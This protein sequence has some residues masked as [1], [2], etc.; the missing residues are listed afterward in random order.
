VVDLVAGL[1]L[2][3]VAALLAAGAHR[4]LSALRRR[5]GL[6]Y[7]RFRER[8]LRAV[9]WLVAAVLVLAVAITV[10]PL[11]V[12]RWA[13]PPTTAFILGSSGC[14][15][16]EHRWVPWSR[17]SSAV[18]IAVVAAEDQRFPR[19]HGFDVAA[20]QEVLEEAGDGERL[21]G[22]ST[23]SQQ[24]AKNLFLWSGRSFVRK[25]LEAWI[26]VW[27]ELAWP[28][29]RILEVYLN[30]AQFDDCVFGVEAAAR[31]Y[32]EKTAGE[33]DGREAAL[34]ATV[35][36]SPSRMSAGRPS[37]YV[38]DRASWVER[39]VDQLGGPAYLGF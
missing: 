26:T 36:P 31:H 33:L 32:F 25:G 19:H 14:D 1:S 4:G 10:V 11:L 27:L 7:P 22:A 35:L 9:A 2:A 28:K 8:P 24:A 29:R 38:R 18:G 37:E 13:P 12:L 3:L 20:I 5:R 21:R 34:L 23:I 16:V 17:I 15:T 6:P 30:V 39:Q